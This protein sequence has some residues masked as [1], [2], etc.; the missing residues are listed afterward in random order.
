MIII[1][2]WWWWQIGKIPSFCL[3]S[4]NFSHLFHSLLQLLALCLPFRN[5]TLFL[6]IFFFKVLLFDLIFLT[7]CRCMFC[8]WT[9]TYFLMFR[10]TITCKFSTTATTRN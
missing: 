10:N 6:I 2:F 9:F 8:L 1:T 4:F 7:D 3:D 5:F